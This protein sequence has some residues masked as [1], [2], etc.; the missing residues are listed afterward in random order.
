MVKRL[1][2]RINNFKEEPIFEK[3]VDILCYGSIILGFVIGI[4]FP[5]NRMDFTPASPDDFTQ[6][7]EQKEVLETDFYSILNMENATITPSTSSIEV[8]LSSEECNLL[9]YF[10]KDFK[11]ISSQ[12]IDNSVSI[13]FVIFASI[14]CGL[15]SAGIFWVFL[16]I[17]VGA[18]CLFN[19]ITMSLLGKLFKNKEPSGTDNLKQQE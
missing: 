18:F 9:L 6:L 10:N 12:K 8:I 11:I 15:L 17:L 7:Y 14:L 19:W 1:K 5:F 4:I 13:Y 3:F 2:K 16:L